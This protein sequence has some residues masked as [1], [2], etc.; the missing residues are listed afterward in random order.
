MVSFGGMG[1]WVGAATEWIA[2]YGPIGW[3]FAGFAAALA[4]VL[5]LL[6]FAWLRYAWIKASATRKWK[7]QS[8]DVNPLDDVFHKKAIKIQSFTNPFTKRISNKKFYDCELI[9][10]AI[11]YIH[12]NNSFIGNTFY[13][14][15]MIVLNPNRKAIVQ[16]AIAL[17]TT[18]IHHSK[19][20]GC[21]LMIEKA[22]ANEFKKIQGAEFLTV[23]PDEGAV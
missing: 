12:T 8:S 16:T 3:L 23:D 11:I 17:E 4:T 6:M 5:I 9:G 21:T 13:F 14:C 7:E 20:I 18:E 22:V 15:D 2:G 19:I 1:A 10:P